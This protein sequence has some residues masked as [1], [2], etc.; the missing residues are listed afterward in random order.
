MYKDFDFYQYH[1]EVWRLQKFA[2]DQLYVRRIP[3]WLL[4]TWLLFQIRA[5]K[6]NVS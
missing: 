4:A 2:Q 6:K 3:L 5:N 1:L